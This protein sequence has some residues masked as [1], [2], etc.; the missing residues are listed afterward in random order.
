MKKVRI[1]L[2]VDEHA[3]RMMLANY[4]L[5]Q[6]GAHR[7]TM[8]QHDIRA[9]LLVAVLNETRGV[10]EEQCH[11]DMPVEWRSNIVAIHSE[12][13]VIEIDDETGEIKQRWPSITEQSQKKGRESI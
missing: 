10:T 13:S 9:A 6:L 3:I 1:T 12:R 8:K 2:E 5:G 7:E 4:T 11:L